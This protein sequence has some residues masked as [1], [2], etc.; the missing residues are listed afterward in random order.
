MSL[1]VKVAIA[2]ALAFLISPVALVIGWFAETD[3]LLWISIVAAVLSPVL[4]IVALVGYLVSRHSRNQV[5][6]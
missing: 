4:L 6:A 1:W 3:A 2:G 5:Q